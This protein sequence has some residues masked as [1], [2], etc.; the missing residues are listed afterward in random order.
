MGP[1]QKKGGEYKYGKIFRGKMSVVP[2][3]REKAFFERRKMLF[4]KMSFG[5][6]RG[7]SS[8][9]TRAERKKG[10]K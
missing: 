8:R 2:G 9:T 3:G 10:T 4:T 1:G 5:K 7:S 6:K